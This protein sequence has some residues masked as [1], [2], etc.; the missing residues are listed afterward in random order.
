MTN[1]LTGELILSKE[2]EE[3]YRF[4]LKLKNIEKIKYLQEL[5]KKIN[6]HEINFF[7]NTCLDIINSNNNLEHFDFCLMHVKQHFIEVTG[8]LKDTSIRF[9]TG[10]ILIS[11][12]T[13][14]TQ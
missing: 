7:N 12:L 6:L 13:Y 11:E 4:V 3:N 10:D 14:L 5:A 1:K 9:T 8:T 2:V